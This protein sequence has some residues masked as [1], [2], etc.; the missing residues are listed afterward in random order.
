MRERGTHG[1]P[2]SRLREIE[3]IVLESPALATILQR[4]PGLCLPNWYLGAG[5]IA[6]T[7]WNRL[8][9]RNPLENIK[10]ADLVYFDGTDLS[11]ESEERITVLARERFSDLSLPID[12]KNQARVHLWYERR[13]GYQIRPYRSVEEAIDSW[14]TTATAVAVRYN[15]DGAFRL[16]AP[17]GLE[18]LFDMIVRPNKVQIT[19]EIYREKVHRW[20]ACW[21]GL[22]VIPW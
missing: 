10:D 5:C 20:K 9:G 19:E 11:P 12:M 7:V 17:Y 15:D 13:F 21:P 18:D 4:A 8:S 2:Q 22:E 14:P 3:R 6:Q 16:Y 1:D